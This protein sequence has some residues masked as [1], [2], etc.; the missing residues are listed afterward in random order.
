MKLKRLLHILG[1]TCMIGAL[2]VSCMEE[3]GK[4]D[5]PL[6]DGEGYV[7]MGL[8]IGDVSA[9]SRAGEETGTANELKIY[10]LRIVLYDGND[11]SASTCK[12]E[13]VFDLDI[14]SPSS[15][16]SVND[17]Q[18]W[19]EGNDLDDEVQL[20]NYKFTLS[21]KRV[22]ERPYKM[23]VLVNGAGISV[24]ESGKSIYDITQKGCFLYQLNEA[25]TATVNPLTGVV[26]GGSGI[27]MSNHQG[28]VSIEKSQLTKTMNDARQRPILANVDRLVA[29]VTV[30]HASN[31]TFPQGVVSGSQTWGLAIT[32]KKTFWMRK[33][34]TGE[35]N[36]SSMANLYAIDPNYDKPSIANMT[37]NFNNLIFKGSNGSVQFAPSAV[38]NSFNEY[39]YA[40]EN[41]TAAVT[42]NENKLYMPQTTHVVVGYKYVPDGYSQGESYFIFNNK[43]VSVAN[44][45]GYVNT[46]SSIPASLQGLDVA[47]KNTSKA[48]YPLDGTSTTYFDTNGIRFCPGGQIYYTFPI[49]H[50]N[51]QEG[52]LGYYGVVRNNIYEI[53]IN[54]LTPP[55]GRES[56]SLSR[57][58]YSSM[59]KSHADYPDWNICIRKKMERGKSLPYLS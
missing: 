3:V 52:N 39:E 51:Q 32:N 44:M 12:V 43:I 53:T 58:K 6:P 5:I 54:S 50:F 40:L 59:G 14:K 27:F 33:G 4:D 24:A 31:F 15:W 22:S 16:S 48:E 57:Y 37:E 23:L 18:G 30:K 7:S 13:Y 56:L 35:A 1:I 55:R 11:N 28:L 47:I 21:P 41:T 26:A 36:Q 49:R 17:I 8:N 45:S 29:K 10:N 9:L 34:T 42:A 19:L 38:S 46:S 2:H 20:S 25:I